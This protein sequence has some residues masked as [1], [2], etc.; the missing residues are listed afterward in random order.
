MSN[1]VYCGGGGGNPTLKP[2]L[3]KLFESFVYS[4]SPHPQGL[5]RSYRNYTD[6][7]IISKAK[8]VYSISGLLKALGLKPR[9]GNY[10]TMK[11]NLFRL[12]VDTSHWTGQAWSKGKQLKDWNGYSRALNMR[13]HLTKALGYVC[14]KCKTD[15]WYNQPITLEIHHL[16]GDKMNNAIENLQFLCPNCHSVTDNFRNKKR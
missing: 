16:D 5:M 14:A 11:A 15:S 3:A 4:I 2:L 10:C 13:K 6:E 1:V 12:K 7:E 9:G 8:E